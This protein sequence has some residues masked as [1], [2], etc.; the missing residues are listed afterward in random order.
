VSDVDQRGFVNQSPAYVSQREATSLLGVKPETLYAYVSRGLVRSER[1]ARGRARRYAREDI[2]RL[3]ARR[4]A[5]SGHGPVAAGALR[6]GEPVLASALTSIEPGGPIYRGI[7]ATRLAESGTFEAVAE[8]LWAANPPLSI[9]RE[10]PP[11]RAPGL[12]VRAAS[13]TALLPED[14]TPLTALLLG[15]PAVGA[16]DPLRF[17]TS[18]E[19][20]RR[21]ARALL[22]RMAALVGLASGR[23]GAREA[24]A[25]DRVARALLVALGARETDEAVAAV[26]CALVLSADHELN[27]SA[28][29]VRVAASAGADLYACVTAGLATLSGP[30]HGGVCDRIE[31]LVAEVR[32][33][34]AASAV[35]LSRS[36]RGEEVP[37]FS[38]PLY[39]AGDPRAAMLLDRVRALGARGQRLRAL[40]SLLDAMRASGREPPSLDFGLVAVAVALDLPPGSAAAIFALG[41]AAGWVAHALEQREQGFILRPRARYT[42]PRASP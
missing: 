16:A 7:A 25:A 1:S 4:D 38:H 36:R 33:P 35:L 23:R 34:E 18:P 13:L 20:E 28:F 9:P 8:L 29:A 39:P 42:G 21:R 26:D 12:G 6:W 10:A 2:E 17:D 19:A 5:R 27:P 30:R 11:F 14:A 41:R 32:R 22:P 31:A 37:G 40:F 3:K 15:V 24:L